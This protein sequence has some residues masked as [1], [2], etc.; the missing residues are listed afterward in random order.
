[1]PRSSKLKQVA[2]RKKLAKGRWPVAQDIKPVVK[3][4]RWR[5][6]LK[7]IFPPSLTATH[8]IPLLSSSLCIPRRSL[9]SNIFPFLTRP[10]DRTFT[11]WPRHLFG[12]RLMKPKSCTH[13]RQVRYGLRHPFQGCVPLTH[14]HR[15]YPQ[16]FIQTMSQ[17][18]P[19][20]SVP[21]VYAV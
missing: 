1:M 12:L 2:Y 10:S 6:M 16:S 21:Y 20:K 17:F 8:S 5:T 19:S 7:N 4:L 15:S 11:F 3:V 14:W 9:R 18:M 13:I